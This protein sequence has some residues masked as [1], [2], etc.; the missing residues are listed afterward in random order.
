MAGDETDEEIRLRLLRKEEEQNQQILKYAVFG[1]FIMNLVVLVF[2]MNSS[3]LL[4][5]VGFYNML[6]FF[7]IFFSFSNVL[8]GTLGGQYVPNIQK[9][10]SVFKML[11]N[12]QV[13]V[14]SFFGITLVFLIIAYL[15]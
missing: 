14:G 15:I 12:D 1:H 4:L 13:V 9:T 5:V 8:K 10:T 7:F 11:S 3:S 2:F 6:A